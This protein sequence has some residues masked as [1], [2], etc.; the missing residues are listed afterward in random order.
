[1]GDQTI[2]NEDKTSILKKKIQ[3]YTR[4]LIGYCKGMV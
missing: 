4:E 3:I 2:N 1:M